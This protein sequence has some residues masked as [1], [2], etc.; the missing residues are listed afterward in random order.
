LRSPRRPGTSRASSSASCSTPVTTSRCIGQ[1]AVRCTHASRRRDVPI[2]GLTRASSGRRRAAGANTS[3]PA[4]TTAVAANTQVG[5]KGGRD[6][7]CG[8]KQ[9]G[10][11]LGTIGHR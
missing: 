1:A 5:P 6:R 4:M 11:R 2:D 7:Q 9:R 10:P 3:N 8:E